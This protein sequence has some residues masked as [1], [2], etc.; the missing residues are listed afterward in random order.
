MTGIL[1]GQALIVILSM[2]IGLLLGFAL[3]RGMVF[4]LE[5]E[6]S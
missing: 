6:D 2:T 3:G 5:E 4:N 1:I